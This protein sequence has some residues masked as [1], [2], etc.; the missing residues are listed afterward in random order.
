MVL[1]ALGVVGVLGE[2]FL[3]A[4]R[5]GPLGNLVWV[6]RH[7]F[8][9]IIRL[10]TLIISGCILWGLGEGL[11]ILVVIVKR[12]GK[13]LSMGMGMGGGL[14]GRGVFWGVGVIGGVGGWGQVGGLGL[15]GRRVEGIRGM[16]EGGM[17]GEVGERVVICVEGVDGIGKG[18]V[19]GFFLFHWKGGW[20]FEMIFLGKFFGSMVSGW[21]GEEFFL[22]GVFFY[23]DLLKKF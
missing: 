13:G 8:R 23:V 4:G 14:W 21:V 19:F 11:G 16:V 2:I 22:F 9:F 15:G 20:V 12:S 17:V 7:I 6:I 3:G 18:G 10:L 1:G 5:K